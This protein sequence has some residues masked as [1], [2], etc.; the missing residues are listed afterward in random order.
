MQTSAPP[1]ISRIPGHPTIV[2]I[3]PQG[4]GKTLFAKALAMKLGSTHVI[5]AENVNGMPTEGAAAVP[6]DGALVIGDEPGGDLTITAHTQAGFDALVMALGIP[7]SHR[8]PYS[9]ESVRGPG[10]AFQWDTSRS[11]TPSAISGEALSSKTD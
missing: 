10:D 5:D 7:L 3:G 1:K 2:L 11:N 4:C 9:R 8:P 6:R